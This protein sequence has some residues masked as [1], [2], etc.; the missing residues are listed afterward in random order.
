MFLP[1]RESPDLS[2]DVAYALAAT[3]FKCLLLPITLH[4]T[5]PSLPCLRRRC[6]CRYRIAYNRIAYHESGEGQPRQRR[7]RDGRQHFKIASGRVVPVAAARE[8]IG[9]E[10]KTTNAK[11]P[12]FFFF[13]SS[14]SPTAKTH[15]GARRC[16]RSAILLCRCRLPACNLCYESTRQRQPLQTLASPL[17]VVVVAAR[18]ERIRSSRSPW[19]RGP[20]RGSS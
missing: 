19:W 17:G 13:I 1:C 9:E 15:G 11:A 12:C 7:E 6:R 14:N 18:A 10:D 2:R 3:C 4:R 8:R 20:Q 16:R 5:T